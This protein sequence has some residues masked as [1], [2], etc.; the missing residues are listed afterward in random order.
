MR[1]GCLIN[2][3]T[4]HNMSIATVVLQLQQFFY[5]SSSA[6]VVSWKEGEEKSVG[7]EKISHIRHAVSNY[8][9]C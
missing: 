2:T 8:F 7:G 3:S 5:A 9:E 6:S 1:V 4:H